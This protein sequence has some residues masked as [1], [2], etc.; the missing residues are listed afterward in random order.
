MKKVR[1][2]DLKPS[3]EIFVEDVTDIV[4][5]GRL[6]TYYRKASTTPMHSCKLEQKCLAFSSR[7]IIWPRIFVKYALSIV[8]ELFRNMF[9]LQTGIAR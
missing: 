7:H 5:F 1:A 9:L 8:I 4:L 6:I 2:K 3:V